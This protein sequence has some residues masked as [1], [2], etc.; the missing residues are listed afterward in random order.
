MKHGN[1]GNYFWYDLDE[2]ELRDTLR[3]L[4]PYILGTRAVNTS[5]D[6]GV[7]TADRHD[8]PVGWP[9]HHGIAVSPPIDSEMIDKWPVSHDDYCDE[10][11]FFAEVPQDFDFA[12][13]ICNYV[14]ERIENWADL[15]F[16][17]GVEL[18][19]NLIRFQPTILV[20]NGKFTYCVSRTRIAA[21]EAEQENGS[22]GMPP[23]QP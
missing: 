5:W 4:N 9:T 11:W 19:K 23:P 13:S 1:V 15:E 2:E 22:A 21:L 14:S 18:K 8:F 7:L 3:R 6:S 16:E 10:W 12:N 20:G 17:G